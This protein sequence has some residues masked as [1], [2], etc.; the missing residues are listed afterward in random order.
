MRHRMWCEL[1]SEAPRAECGRG[2]RPR[3]YTLV[4]YLLPRPELSSY[5]PSDQW[6]PLNKYRKQSCAQ[7]KTNFWDGIKPSIHSTLYC[8]FLHLCELWDS[9]A[10]P[11]SNGMNDKWSACLSLLLFSR[12]VV[13]TLWT[14]ELQHARLPGPSSPRACSNS[15]P[16]RQWCHPII[17]SSVAPFPSLALLKLNVRAN[18][19]FRALEILLKHSFYFIWSQAGLTLAF[20]TSPQTRPVMLAWGP[21]S[22]EH[23]EYNVMLV[24]Y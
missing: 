5:I 4:S 17:S 11:E 6:A 18:V 16:L 12:S 14:H 9:R 22:E 24:I 3:D 13:S 8:S 15:C 19:H 2:G 21:H 23:S 7:N 1:R 10:E 20:L